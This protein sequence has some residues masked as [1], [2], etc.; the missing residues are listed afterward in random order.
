MLPRELET[1]RITK[2]LYD[3]TCISNSLKKSYLA[4][5]QIDSWDKE[6]C[7][8]LLKNDNANYVAV[9]RLACL[10]D[11]DE[12]KR[13]LLQKVLMQSVANVGDR[14]AAAVPA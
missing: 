4:L 1:Q 3:L 10:S 8:Q 9:Y 14:H 13:N 11:N 12:E 5:E 7:M 2:A 6:A